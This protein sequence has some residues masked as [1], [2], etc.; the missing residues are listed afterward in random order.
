MVRGDVYVFFWYNVLERI[1][2]VQ[3]N[4]AV[5][6]I[7]RYFFLFEQFA[8]KLQFETAIIYGIVKDLMK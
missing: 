7:T 8:F 5:N 2:Q 6:A 4:L 3:T 1:V